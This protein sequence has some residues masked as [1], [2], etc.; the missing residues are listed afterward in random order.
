MGLAKLTSELKVEHQKLHETINHNDINLINY[1]TFPQLKTYL[2]HDVFG[3]MEVIEK[4]G[5]G[6]WKDLGIDITSCFTGASLSKINFFKNYYNDKKHPVY[7]LSDKNDKFIRNSYFGGRVECHKM[8]KILKAYYYDFTSLYPDVG[9]KFLPY[10]EPELMKL[11]PDKLPDGF[12]G[13]VR[14]MVKTKNKKAVPKHAMLSNSRLIFPICENWT[15]MNLFS[16]ELDYDIYE[17]QF[18][19]GV[20][21][22]KA[23]FKKK[24]FND[25]FMKKALSKVN[26]NPAMAQ[27]YKIII[28]SGYGFWGLRTKDRDGVMIFEPNDNSYRKYLDTDKLLSIREHNDYVFCR[29]MKDLDVADFNV[30]VAAAISS[31]A[32]SKLHSLITAIRE[33]GGKVYYMDTD[34]VICSINLND[35]IHIKNKYQWDGDSLFYSVAISVSI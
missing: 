29:V 14:C 8:G 30:A 17:Y 25:G 7:K 27:A 19:E 1:H 2:T 5:K 13:W 11:K 20:K 16:E 26:G 10:G 35:H 4:F 28:N 18:I 24:F 34:S 23:K 12:F 3:L 22:K 9:R 6:V 31:Y 32:R 33:V 15:E 21:F